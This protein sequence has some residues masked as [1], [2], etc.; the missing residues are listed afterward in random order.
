MVYVL[1]YFLLVKH[2]V[3]NKKKFE[4]DDNSTETD[5]DDNDQIG[6]E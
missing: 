2:P 6:D 5:K 1:Q 4:N 3:S